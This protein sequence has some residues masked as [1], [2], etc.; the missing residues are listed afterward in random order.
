MDQAVISGMLDIGD[1]ER[2]EIK[3]LPCEVC[4]KCYL[5]RHRSAAAT[6]G[7]PRKR[8]TTSVDVDMNH[9]QCEG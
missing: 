3:T 7:E 2:G 4:E 5:K 8:L 1:R 6:V 9:R